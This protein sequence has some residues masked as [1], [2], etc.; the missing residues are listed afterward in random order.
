M[1]RSGFRRGDRQRAN[2]LFRTL[3]AAI[4]QEVGDALDENAEELAE[5]IRRRVPADGGDLTASVRWERGK[6]AQSRG[7]V[8][9]RA[10]GAD[11]DL[12]V[13]VIEGDDDTFYAGYVEH[14]TVNHP[15]QPHFF[16]TYRQLRRQLQARLRRAVTK[17]VRWKAANP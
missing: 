10:A 3:P 1:S 17:A 11:A 15:A 4:R 5:A 13:R 2:A 7:G 12:T 9:T 8:Q 16:P 6:A 14:G